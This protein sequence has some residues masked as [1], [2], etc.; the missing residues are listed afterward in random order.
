[1]ATKK[2]KQKEKE[3][4]IKEF[5]FLIVKNIPA[6]SDYT[7]CEHTSRPVKF[8]TS[9]KNE[10]VFSIFSTKKFCFCAMHPI[11]ATYQQSLV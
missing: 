6:A 5:L 4:E 9:S 10:N 7:Q 8:A 1:M 2:R 11:V 3:D